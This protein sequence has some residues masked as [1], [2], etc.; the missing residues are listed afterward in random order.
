MGKENGRGSVV[1]GGVGVYGRIEKS[2]A[3]ISFNNI[4]KRDPLSPSNANT[5]AY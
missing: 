3:P 4:I 5:F 2:P 1:G